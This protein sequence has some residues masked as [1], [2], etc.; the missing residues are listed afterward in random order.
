MN[1]LL[2]VA[3]GGALGALLRFGT[4]KLML[5]WLGPAWP[6]GTL[7]VNV[8]GGLVMGLVTGWAAQRGLPT[9]MKLF[10]TTGLLGGFTTF[11]AFSLET[12]Q[13]LERGE[14][15]AAAAY[16]AASVLLSVGALLLGLKLIRALA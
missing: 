8:V 3:L 12:V 6:W 4:G 7:S 10:L 15:G 9:D 11:S 16:V 1:A 5:T 14:H 13:M 2:A